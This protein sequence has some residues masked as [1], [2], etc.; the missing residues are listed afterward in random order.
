MHALL[1]KLLSKRGV[2]K[3]SLDTKPLFQGAPSEKEQ[4]FQWEKILSGGDLT[5]DKIRDFCKDQ[6]KAIEGQWK[7]LNN[8]K[9]KNER[10]ILMHTVYS[11][12]I[13]SI[14]SP[15]AERESLEKYLINLINS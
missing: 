3:E 6:I 8:S 14:E 12:I 11:T 13:K 15:Q 2:D 1:S 9:E 5:V 7:D 10:L 4:F